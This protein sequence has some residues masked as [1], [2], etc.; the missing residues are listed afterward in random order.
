MKRNLLLVPLIALIITATSCRVI[1]TLTGDED[2]K[3]VGDLWSDVPR[4]EGLAA[5]EAEMP[6]QVK[7]LMRYALNNLW[8]LNKEGED[9]TKR[10]MVPSAGIHGSNFDESQCTFAKRPDLPAGCT[11]SL[12]IRFTI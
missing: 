4:M 11:Q 3:K 7:L 6:V 2:L 10:P 5:S 1:K 8:R 12:R 9:K